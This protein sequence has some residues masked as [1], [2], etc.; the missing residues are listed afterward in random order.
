[1]SNSSSLICLTICI[2]IVYAVACL[3]SW[4]KGALPGTLLK[5]LRAKKT[6]PE[7]FQL[8]EAEISPDLVLSR[9]AVVARGWGGHQ[10]QPVDH[11]APE[12]DRRNVPDDVISV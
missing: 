4:L 1:M 6:Y 10:E 8:Q 11:N 12:A 2:R 5:Q 7:A 9:A 3:L